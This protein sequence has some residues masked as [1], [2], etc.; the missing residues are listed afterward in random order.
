MIILSRAAQKQTSTADKAQH[1]LETDA[2]DA[3]LQ[4]MTAAFSSDFAAGLIGRRH[5]T[6]AHRTRVLRQMSADLAFR[7]AQDAVPT[8]QNFPE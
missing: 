1:H 6:F 5:N 4:D 2:L 7:R 3:A 8:A